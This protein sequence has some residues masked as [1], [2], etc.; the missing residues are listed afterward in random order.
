MMSCAANHDV[1]REVC[2]TVWKRL[3]RRS[4]DE[5]MNMERLLGAERRKVMPPAM[6]FYFEQCI[7]IW[8]RLNDGLIWVLIGFQDHI[9]R[10][11]CHRKDRPQLAS[12]NP[13]GIQRLLKQLNADPMTIAIWSDATTC[14]DLGDESPSG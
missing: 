7:Q 8:R 14:V 3:H 11:A 12:A 1:F 4:I 5:I 10:T 13:D 9:I 2:H 6:I